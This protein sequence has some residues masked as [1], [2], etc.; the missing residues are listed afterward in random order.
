MRYLFKPSDKIRIRLFA[1]SFEANVFWIAVAGLIFFAIITVYRGCY[2]QNITEQ[3]NAVASEVNPAIIQIQQVIAI[4][5]SLTEENRKLKSKIVEIQSEVEL[6][7]DQI[8]DI[9]EVKPKPV[10]TPKKKNTIYLPA[11]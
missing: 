7:K 9:K 4:K 2:M 5:D 11:E 10:N 1:N 6:L 8:K 3:Y